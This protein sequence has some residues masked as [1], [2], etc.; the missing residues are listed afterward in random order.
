MYYYISEL[1]SSDYLQ[2]KLHMGP[3]WDFDACLKGSE[4]YYTDFETWSCQH[5]ANYTYFGYF[6]EMPSFKQAYK[7]AWIELYEGLYSDL[8]KYIYELV[9]QDGVA[10]EESR[11]MDSERWGSSMYTLNEEV[12]YDMDFIGRRI[13]FINS[14]IK[15]W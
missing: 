11:R 4:K 1:N 10:I 15:E 6:F 13:E 3:L 12:S 2:N 5:D 8:S 9:D 14:M 7:T